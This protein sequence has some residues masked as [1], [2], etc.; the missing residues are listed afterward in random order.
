[1]LPFPQSVERCGERLGQSAEIQ[2]LFEM[3]RA[4]TK[5]TLRSDIVNFLR[6]DGV[7]AGLAGQRHG[8]A[9]DDLR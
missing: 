3:F 8:F 4:Q 2:I 6:D 7:E 1:M 9:G 5:V